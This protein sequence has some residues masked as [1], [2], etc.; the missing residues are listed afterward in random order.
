MTVNF[1]V[2]IGFEEWAIPTARYMVTGL[3]AYAKGAGWFAL[4]DAKMLQS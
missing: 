3:E 4:A 2:S 1:Y